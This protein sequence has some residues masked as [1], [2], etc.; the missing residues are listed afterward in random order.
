MTETVARRSG[1]DRVVDVTCVALAVLV[2]WVAALDALDTGRVSGVYAL[3]ASAAA[4]LGCA[5]LW[6]RRRWPVGVA[7]LTALLALPTDFV[8]GAATVAVFTVAVHR[9]WR[10]TVGV[11]LLHLAA[12]LP[13]PL[14]RPD[15]GLSAAASFFLSLMFVLI[16]VVWGMIV[17]DRRELRASLR[18]V[19]AQ[20]EAE[21]THRADR[22]RGLER[23]RIAREMHDVLAHRIS[24]VSLHAGALEI[25]PDAPPGEVARA[26]GIIRASAHQALEDLRETLGVLRAGGDGGPLHPQPGLAGVDALVAEA[27]EAGTEVVLARDLPPAAAPPD[28]VSRTAYRIVQEGLTNAR[29]HAPGCAVTVGLAGAPGGPLHVRLRNPLGPPPPGP[30]IPGSRS[31]LVGLAE[32]VSLAGGRFEQGV[33]REPGGMLAFH[34]EAWLPW[35]R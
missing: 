28:S 21:A 26:A 22:Q 6:V 33:R 19:V 23:E 9:P 35:P 31:G 25:R 29:K 8:G 27:R 16:A 5:A 32:R 4:A 15:P 11:A 13:Y 24:L 20:A 12:G 17:R 7:L 34:L 14:V 30:A 1:R 18:A 10:V 3:A 2:W